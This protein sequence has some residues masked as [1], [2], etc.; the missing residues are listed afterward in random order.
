MQIQVNKS[1]KIILT[2]GAGLV[3]QNLVV[4]LKSQGYNNLV[5]LDK[6]KKNLKILQDLQPELDARYCDLAKKGN[7]EESFRGCDI[8]IMLQAQIGAK[9]KGP[10]IRNNIDSTKNVIDATQKHRVPYIIHISSSVVES[11]A[12]DFYTESKKKQEELVLNCGIESVALRPTLMFGWFDRKHLGW[13]SRFMKKMP[14]FPIPGHGKYMRQPLYAG[15]F[16]NIIISCI[17]KKPSEKIYNITGLEKVDY[18]DI[19]KNIKE[20]T[21]AKP[22]ILKIPYFSFHLL[23]KIWAIFDKDPPFTTSQL[24]ALITDDAS[25]MYVLAQGLI[26]AGY[27]K[28]TN[29]DWVR[30]LLTWAEMQ[31]YAN[32]KGPTTELVVKA[33]KEGTPTNTIGRIG[34]STRQAPQVGTT[35]GAGMRVGRIGLIFP[36]DIHKT[37]E[38][39]LLTCLP[40]HDTNIAIASACAISSAVSIAMLRDSNVDSII[41]ASV[42]GA[43]YGE[44]LAK[45][46]LKLRPDHDID[47]VVDRIVVREGMETR[48]ADS[49]RTALDL[50]DGIAILE[51]APSEGEPERITFSENF[52]CPTALAP[53]ASGPLKPVGPPSE[54]ASRG[55]SRLTSRAEDVVAVAP[56]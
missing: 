19:I 34:N 55:L 33:L 27:G 47:V 42:E 23:L 32:Y 43:K 38:Q 40:S 48:L 13:L 36:G 28:F 26:D 25:Q 30:C 11:A 6:H 54:L 44:M 8:L 56:E 20:V 41:Q 51:T 46:V 9:D 53:Q 39:T 45:K 24:K 21:K 7:W 10:F 35:N 18:I 4:R 12:C 17:N 15:D 14:I 16:C 22:F 2:G 37:C 5:I 3:G 31:P 50:A 49:F 29:T 1:Q 52:A